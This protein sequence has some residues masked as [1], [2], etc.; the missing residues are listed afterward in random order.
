MPR[1][2]DLPDNVLIEWGDFVPLLAA[3]S[4]TAVARLPWPLL[5][6]LVVHAPVLALA[7]T[8]RLAAHL[9]VLGY[10][11]VQTVAATFTGT[12]SELC[13]VLEAIAAAP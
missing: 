5:A 13:E 6:A 10:D 8:D 12:L 1:V 4:Q 9:G 2:A 11:V 7:C 3:I